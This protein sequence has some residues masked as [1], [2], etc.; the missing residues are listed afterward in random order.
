MLMALGI[1][2]QH[3]TI[4]F[5][6]LKEKLKHLRAF[7][8]LFSSFVATLIW[9]KFGFDSYDLDYLFTLYVI[10]TTIRY[11]GFAYQGKLKQK[12][13]LFTIS[14]VL[15][16]LGI[17]VLIIDLV[18]NTNLI[19]ALYLIQGA[20]TVYVVYTFQSKVQKYLGYIIYYLTTYV[21]IMDFYIYGF[22]EILVWAV[23][24]ATFYLQVLSSKKAKDDTGFSVNFFAALFVHVLFLYLLDFDWLIFGPL[25]WIAIIGSLYSLYLLVKEKLKVVTRRIYLGVNVFVHLM[26]IAYLAD[27]FIMDSNLQVFSTTVGWG[28]YALI[29]V[30]HGMKRQLK[31]LR[32]LGIGLLFFTLLKLIFFDLAF[33][34]LTTR[35]ILFV[36]IG[37]IGIVVSRITYGKNK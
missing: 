6:L 24:I 32:L 30:F 37:L 13:E 23:L 10:S 26:F 27:E 15:A 28:L 2:I 31:S 11:G 14:M 5:T 1:I 7:P 16:T 19:A 17:S 20:L 29:C 25:Y 3:E 35:S 4:F 33:I 22:E 21:I 9:A 18:D 8:L 34:S 12:K 36:L